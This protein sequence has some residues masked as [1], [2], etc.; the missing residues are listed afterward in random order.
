MNKVKV[1]FHSG[2][3]YLGQ[4]LL[5][6]GATWAKLLFF[7]A[8]GWVLLLCCCLFFDSIQ[9]NHQRTPHPSQCKTMLYESTQL[10]TVVTLNLMLP[11]HLAISPKCTLHAQQRHG[12]RT[13]C[14]TRQDGT[15]SEPPRLFHPSPESLAAPSWHG[16]SPT[17]PRR[18]LLLRTTCPQPPAPR[19]PNVLWPLGP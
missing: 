18:T 10:K 4:F 11:R 1:M 9:M 17:V 12:K 8:R 7:S 14:R 13:R 6:P 5:G 3:S 2:P 19:R 15:P 16:L